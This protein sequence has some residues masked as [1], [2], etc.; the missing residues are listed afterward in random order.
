MSTNSL[1]VKRKISIVL[2]TVLGFIPYYLIMMGVRPSFLRISAQDWSLPLFYIFYCIFLAIILFLMHKE[3]LMEA[4]GLN[5]NIAYGF[6]YSLIA[7]LPMLLCNII[8]KGFNNTESPLF[9]FNT[10]VTAGFFEE[11]L[12]RGF[13]LGQLFRYARWGFIPTIL[14]VAFLFGLGHIFQGTTIQSAILSAS[15]TGLGAALFGW[16]FI[17]TNYNLWCCAFLHILMNFSWSAFATTDNGAIGDTVSNITR[18]STVAI[19]I[20]L[21]IIYKKK[22]HRPYYIN[23]QTLWKNSEI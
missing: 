19:A 6:A 17:E 1:T 5:K 16:I 21:V 12:F 4:I 14:L 11:L 23:A 15:T 10:S 8:M 18:I 13:L 3:Q 22:A 2:L 7:V 9:L 20:L